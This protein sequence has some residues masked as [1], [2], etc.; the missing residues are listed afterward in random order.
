MIATLQRPVRRSWGV[1]AKG[2]LVAKGTVDRAQWCRIPSQLKA[3]ILEACLLIDKYLLPSLWLPGTL[4]F[5]YY[6]ISLKLFT[7]FMCKMHWTYFFPHSTLPQTPSPI[8]SPVIK[9][10][11]LTLVKFTW[12]TDVQGSSCQDHVTTWQTGRRRGPFHA[13]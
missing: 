7:S 2:F 5:N 4:K 9:G 1:C 6:R 12:Q 8:L 3:L 11:F 13:G 10:P